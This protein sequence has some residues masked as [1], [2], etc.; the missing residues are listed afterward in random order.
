ADS[1]F[2]TTYLVSEFARKSVTVT[3]SGVG[4]DEL[5]GGYRRYLGSEIARYYNVLPKFLRQRVVPDLVKRLPV[6]R[7][8]SL[9]NYVRYAKAFVDSDHL[10]PEASYVKYLTVFTAEA[11]AAL[12][13]S[14]V[15]ACLQ[16]AASPPVLQQYWAQSTANDPLSRMM[17]LDL[18]TQ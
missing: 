9:G 14:D 6:D 18:K 10:G 2:I 8:S 17:F 11:K 16:Q 12:L 1:A 4:G 15:M 7:H 13:C 3:L 5:F